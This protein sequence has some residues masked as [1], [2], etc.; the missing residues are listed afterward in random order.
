MKISKG[1]LK[2]IFIGFPVIS[3]IF[4]LCFS[5]SIK[6]EKDISFCTWNLQTFFDST[7]NGTEYAEF[8]K[9]G[10]W[11]EEKYIQRLKRLSK[12][13]LELNSD[14]FV[15]EEIENEAVVQDIANFLAVSS[16]KIKWRYACFATNPGSATGCAVFSKFPLSDV[17]VHSL[18]V[19]TQKSIQPS[20]RPLLCVYVH[21]NRSDFFVFANHWKS[22]SGGQNKSEIWRDWQELVLA[23]NLNEKLLVQ[24]E[25][26]ILI[27]GD[28]NRDA[29]DFVTAFKT[30]Y[31]NTFL[32][33]ILLDKT[34]PQVISWKNTGVYSPW[35][36]QNGSFAFES[37]SYFYKDKWERIDNIFTKNIDVIDFLPQCNG[38][39]ADEKNRP[40]TYRIYNAQ[41]YSDHL[42]LTC[43]IKL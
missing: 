17:K 25:S 20:M 5:C 6:K 27:C 19:R 1:Y 11:T 32:R 24:P 29:S 7:L 34:S 21:S 13:M 42:P 14:I 4:F 30:D 31:E 36:L 9:P 12:S 8:K 15:F 40:C 35:F 16:W 10:A 26:K 28:F 43:K 18:D 41:G 38:Q 37:G 3:A 2:K 23:Y 39:W 33:G 22:K